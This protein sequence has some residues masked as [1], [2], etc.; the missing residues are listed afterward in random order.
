MQEM[1]DKRYGEEP[2]A[3]GVEPNEYF[4]QIILNKE[5]GALLL[6]GEGEGRNAVYA[7]KLGWKV[8]AYDYSYSAK[9]KAQRLAEEHD[10]DI[11]YEIDDLMEVT[12]PQGAYDLAALIFFHLSESTRA[13]VHRKI[14]AAIK[15]GG[16]LLL[17]AFT[18]EQLG[19]KSGGPKKESMLYTIERLQQDFQG[20]EILHAENTETTLNE[21]PYHQGLA[22]VVRFHLR[23]PLIES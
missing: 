15:P 11:Q 17:E 6:P 21:G 7:A 5:P 19:K 8:Q 2:Y 13:Q 9:T 18:P 12:L 16:E 1:W 22:S 10:V 20:C 14:L 23:K 3:Y 4:K